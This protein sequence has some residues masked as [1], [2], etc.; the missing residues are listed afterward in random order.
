[1]EAARR[2]HGVPNRENSQLHNLP[3]SVPFSALG[4]DDLAAPV[5]RD[6]VPAVD[7]LYRSVDEKHAVSVHL[8]KPDAY[9][10]Q[11]L[12]LVDHLNAVDEMLQCDYYNKLDASDE[13]SVEHIFSTMDLDEL[14]VLANVLEEHY[15]NDVGQ[16][17]SLSSAFYCI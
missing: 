11:R 1:V 16:T 6:K 13:D 8:N 2:A 5:D 14:C 17:K 10:N 9:P 4:L 12:S 3:L 15:K 7:S